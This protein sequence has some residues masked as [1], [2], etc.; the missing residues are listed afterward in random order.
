MST[1]LGNPWPNFFSQVSAQ[2]FFLQEAFLILSLSPPHTPMTLTQSGV[3]AAPWAPAAPG[4]YSFIILATSI[5]ALPQE[6]W[7]IL[8]GKT[9]VPHTLES[10]APGALW[11]L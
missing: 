9:G 7:E 2:Y 4:T 8:E 5:N 3:P 6:Y 1:K 11:V 10:L